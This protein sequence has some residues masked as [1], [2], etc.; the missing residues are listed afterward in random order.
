MSAILVVA[1]VVT[2]FALWFAALL[3]IQWWLIEDAFRD[4]GGRKK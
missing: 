2:G 1:G 4:I 3:L